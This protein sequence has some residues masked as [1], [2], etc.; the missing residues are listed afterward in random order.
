MSPGVHTFVWT[1]PTVNLALWLIMTKSMQQEWP[2]SSGAKPQ[3]GQVASA[4]MFFWAL[5][6]M[7]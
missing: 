2:V 3:E 4:F 1:P 5:G 7:Q 6:D